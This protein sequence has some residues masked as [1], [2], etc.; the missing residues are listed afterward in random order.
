M[1]N[2]RVG[3]TTRGCHAHVW[4]GIGHV[5][6]APPLQSHQPF[7]TDWRTSPSVSPNGIMLQKRM[8]ALQVEAAMFA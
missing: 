5:Q 8:V 7:D 4:V 3:M 1:P 6:P 2:V